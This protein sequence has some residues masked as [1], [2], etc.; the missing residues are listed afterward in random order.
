MKKQNK[1]QARIEIL[2]YIIQF[3]T[4]QCFSE[5]SFSLGRKE[6][7]FHGNS[8]NKQE[9]PIG[10]LCMLSS[11]P[12]SIYY[13]GW[14]REI[15]HDDSRFSTQ[16]LIESIEDGSRCWWHNVGIWYLPIETSDRFPSWQWTDEQFA[17]QKKYDNAF[18]KRHAYGLRALNAVFDMDGGVTVKIRRMWS[19]DIFAEKTFSNYKKVLSRDL[20]KFYDETL[21]M[22]NKK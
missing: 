16:F 7:S 2:N 14:L 22:Y 6:T 19:N 20:L 17:F 4:V 1:N 9:P 18:R 8:F 11:V 15:K 12:T 13:L 3:C 5:N 10:S 21:I